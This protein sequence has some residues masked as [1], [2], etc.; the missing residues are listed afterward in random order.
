MHAGS[1]RWSDEL[2]ADL[3]ETSPMRLLY[4]SGTYAPGAFAGSE[5]SAHTLLRSL[6]NDHGVDVLVATDDRY[7][8][9]AHEVCEFDGVRLIGIDHGAR[10][11][12][13]G[14]VMERFSPQVIFTQPW[15]HD[16]ALSLGRRAGFPTILRVVDWPIPARFFTDVALV[17]SAI[18][19]QTG[20][21]EREIRRLSSVRT[22]QLP[23]F[24]D[25]ARAQSHRPKRREYITMFNP[26]EVKGGFLFKAIAERLPGRLFAIVPGWS[27]LRDADGR[28]DRELIRRNAESQGSQYDGWLPVEP[29]FSMTANVTVLRPREAIDEILD[30]TR[31]VLVPSLWK[32]QFARVIF[33]AAAN[34][35]AVIASGMPSL[36][37]NAGDAAMFVDDFT[38]PDAWVKAIASLD[39]SRSYEA[40]CR[41]GQEYV[42]RNYD[43]KGNVAKFHALARDLCAASRC[44]SPFAP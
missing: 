16:V 13:L 6:S 7:T 5:L 26:I 35:A 9:G 39:N 44:S 24:I 25:L 37:E 2:S 31:I 42:L 20:E 28:F 34:G 11:E 29:D 36:R 8:R 23:A 21:A 10:A 14:R 12:V 27:S 33:E 15:W 40:R 30:Q 32:E 18:V 22:V 38:N 17:P 43:L 3:R 19:V 4:V 1:S 41:M